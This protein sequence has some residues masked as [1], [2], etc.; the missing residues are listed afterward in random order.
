M[1]YG[2]AIWLWLGT[3]WR[4]QKITAMKRL[5]LGQNQC[6]V[7]SQGTTKDCTHNNPTRFN[8][9][10]NALCPLIAEEGRFQIISTIEQ[11]ET[12]EKLPMLMA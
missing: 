12:R 2:R 11:I 8:A 6:G 5:E 9:E 4:M 7:Y 3:I 10:A 1:I